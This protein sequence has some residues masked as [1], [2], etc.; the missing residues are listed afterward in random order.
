MCSHPNALRIKRRVATIRLNKK[1]K[2]IREVFLSGKKKGKSARS[3][4]Q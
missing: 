1:K 4:S 3:Q 2:S